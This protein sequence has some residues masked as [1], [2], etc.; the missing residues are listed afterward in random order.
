MNGKRS[1]PVRGLV[2]WWEHSMLPR[3]CFVVLIFFGLISPVAAQSSIAG[4]LLRT[5]VAQ[6]EVTN[7]DTGEGG[8]CNGFVDTVRNDVAYVAT[9]KHCAEE[10]AGA[11]L[12]S[13]TAARLSITVHY[14]SGGSGILR[15]LF[16]N[17][18]H[19]ELVIAATFDGRPQSYAGEC[20]GCTAYRT[21]GTNQRIPVVSVLS[22]GGGSPVVSSGFVF[23]DESSR[24]VVALPGAPG[25]SGAPVL[26]LQGRLV[27]IVVGGRVFGSAEAGFLTEIIPGGL[28]VDLVRYAVEWTEQHPASPQIPPPIGPTAQ[29]NDGTYSYA[30]NHQG[31]C[32]HHGG[33]AQWYR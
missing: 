4:N 28:V 1:S 9:A 21:F 3:I 27:G 10:P 25:T 2:N 18:G 6:I 13:D 8:F 14:S 22:A 16:W 5:I 30:A 26:D 31:A 7:K 24:Y 17:T 29:C 15:Q 12:S 23:A 33:V 20:T 32:S 11:H 19:D